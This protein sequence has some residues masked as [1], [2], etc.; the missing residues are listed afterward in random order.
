MQTR[1]ARVI[2]EIPGPA[3]RRLVADEARRLAPG[4]QS[5]GLFSGIALD[6]GHGALVTD[7]DG[8]TFIDFTAG[9]GVA[10]LGHAHPAYVRALT[11]Q[12]ESITV[13]SYT[14]RRR[15]EFLDELAPFLPAGLTRMQ[16]YSG[17]AE[18]VEA[19][20]R[21][22]RSFTGRFEVISFWGGFHGK[23]GS[24]LGLSGPDVKQGLGPLHPGV[25]NVPYP[26]WARPPFPAATP[27]ELGEQCIS[28]LRAYIRHS[29][30]GSLAAIVV[31]PI[32]GTA[33][34]VVPPHGF[35]RAAAQVAHEHGGLFIADEMI[36]GFARTGRMFGCE[37]FDVVPDAMT[38]GKGI[39]NGF[40]VAGLIGREELMA[41]APFG[42]PS[43]SSSS[44][45]GNPLAG[46]AVHATLRAIC[47][48]QLV[49]NAERVGAAMRDR[50][51]R[52]Q[53]RFPFIGEVRGEG[54]M[55]GVDVVL[56]SDGR[57]P[58]PAALTR[59]VFHAALRR[60]LLAMCYG[61]RIRINPPLVIDLAT[62]LEGV[63][64]LEDAFAELED[65]LT[66]VRAC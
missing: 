35:L 50:L 60:G 3:S 53:R 44:Y 12:L 45:G 17:G 57:T 59:K 37:H 13:G 26:D 20:L 40:P 47:D 27:A 43:G 19:A 51:R 48:E 39:A 56:A 1:S 16:F 18:A 63:S 4:L 8:N 2:T 5:I 30:A 49:S 25:H 33:G 22:A 31:E 55:I 38:V 54:L 52:L 66:S 64:I 32:Q 21:M 65:E 15:A 11:E 6:H 58:M 23:T 42:L 14:T 28:F 7:V 46:A 9:V 41:A 61:P 29:T 62:A 10:S 24:T 36:T 34:N